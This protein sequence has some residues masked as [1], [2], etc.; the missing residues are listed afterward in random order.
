MLGF[1]VRNSVWNVNEISF[2]ATGK[3]TFG[4][5]SQRHAENHIIYAC[6]RQNREMS[7]VSYDGSQL[8]ALLFLQVLPTFSITLIS[9]ST[10]FAKQ[11]AAMCVF[12]VWDQA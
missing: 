6:R 12:V 2:N 3:K 1:G 5:L 4:S 10:T 9:L 8:C 7:L 11:S